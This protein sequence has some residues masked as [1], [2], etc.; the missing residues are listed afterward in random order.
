[1]KT[2]VDSGTVVDFD[3]L[4]PGAVFD[5]E[6][7]KKTKKVIS[8][9]KIR[10]YSN[11]ILSDIRK[12]CVETK[13][14]YKQAKKFAQLQRIEYTESNDEQ[15]KEMLW[16]YV[17]LDWGGFLDKHNTQIPCTRENKIKFMSKWPAFSAWV[18]K[19]LEILAPDVNEAIKE[20]GKN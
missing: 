5:F 6:V 16:D 15:I 11:E 8:W 4:N 13:V 19:C 7:D 17:I 20:S 9:V 18:D 14:E 3:E 10:S 1:M 2:I 12:K